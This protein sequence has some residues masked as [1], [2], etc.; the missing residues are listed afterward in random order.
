MKVALFVTCLVD[1]FFPEVGRAT[2]KILRRLGCEVEF[3]SAQTCCG[4]PAFN[5]GFRAEAKVVARKFIK[6]FEP[7]EYIVT[8]SGSCAAMVAHFY[9][10]LFS[11][12]PETLERARLLAPKIHELSEFLVNVLHVENIG[13]KFSGTVTF[14]NSCHLLR[15][16]KVRDEPRKLI[17]G[18]QGC[19][20]IEL[21]HSEHCCGFGGMFSIKLPDI[22]VGIAEEKIKNIV[23]SGAQVLVACDTS[24]LMHIAG[25]M[26][27]KNIPCKTMHLAELLAQGL[28]S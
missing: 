14:H 7:Y 27:R 15:H 23:A 12:E 26:S 10:E 2:V 28:D 22:S 25:A 3:P 5:S 6:E 21:P 24:C 13:S 11:D 17:R 18:V 16:L 1:Q 20:L 19:Q 9:Q 4:Q 8:P